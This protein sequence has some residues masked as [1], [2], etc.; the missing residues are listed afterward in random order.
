MNKY[1]LLSLL[2]SGVGA[3]LATSEYLCVRNFE[4]DAPLNALVGDYLL[5]KAEKK[6]L[7]KYKA[8]S[9]G[10]AANK[11]MDE[12]GGN[13]APKKDTLIIIRTDDGKVSYKGVVQEGGSLIKKS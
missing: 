9:G 5:E 4:S 13:F 1:L 12:Y 11:C 8:T 10:N 2:V 6:A 7:A 3:C